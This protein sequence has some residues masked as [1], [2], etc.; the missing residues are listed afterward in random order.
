MFDL[1]GGTFDLSLLES[2][3]GILEVLATAGDTRLG[4][5]N[6]DADIAKWIL[7]SSGLTGLMSGGSSLEG[8]YQL[9]YNSRSRSLPSEPC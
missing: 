2:F 1:G 9:P 7:Q 8:S 4:G 6:F 3:E 5:N